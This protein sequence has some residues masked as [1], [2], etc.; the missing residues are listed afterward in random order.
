MGP[1][2]AGLA[3]AGILGVAGCTSIVTGDSSVDAGD[4]PAYRASVSVS[5]SAAAVT[6]SVRESQR[7]ASV[8]TQAVRTVCETLSTSSA[9]AVKTVNT[10]VAAMNSGGD[11]EA[12]IEPARE[13]LNS[14]AGRVSAEINDTLP[15]ELRDA[16]TAWADASR[17]A[18]EALAGPATPS[19]FNTAIDQV[20]TTRTRALNLCDTAY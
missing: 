13:A 19:E 3:A 20:N 8:T 4:V 6:S 11:V 14:S 5:K 12:T 17:A 9:E 10:Y 16:L 7:Q 2:V 18:G 15:A 1:L